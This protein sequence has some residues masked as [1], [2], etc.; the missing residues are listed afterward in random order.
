MRGSLEDRYGNWDLRADAMPRS[1]IDM[2]DEIVDAFDVNSPD[3]Q[4][5]GWDREAVIEFMIKD[6][7]RG[8]CPPGVEHLGRKGE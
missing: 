2:V 6:F 3:P 7:H 4:Q 8:W 5:L 1:L